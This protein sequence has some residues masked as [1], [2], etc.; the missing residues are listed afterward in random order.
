LVHIAFVVGIARWRRKRDRSDIAG[1]VGK[2]V[3]F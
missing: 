1:D 3:I 2:S